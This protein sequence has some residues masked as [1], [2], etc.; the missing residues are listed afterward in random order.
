MHWCTCSVCGRVLLIEHGPTCPECKA[1]QE[2]GAKPQAELESAPK[3][4]P[5]KTE[6]SPKKARSGCCG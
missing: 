4:A 3:P 6:A 1:K 2:T 5:Q